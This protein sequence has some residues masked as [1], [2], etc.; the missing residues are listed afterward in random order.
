[1]VK[2]AYAKPTMDEI[3]VEGINLMAGSGC[4]EVGAGGGNE[5]SDSEECAGEEAKSGQFDFSTPN[6][7]AFDK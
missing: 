7:E 1:M 6:T 3:K 2:K 5:C 4:G